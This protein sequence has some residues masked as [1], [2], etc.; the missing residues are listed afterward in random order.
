MQFSSAKSTMPFLYWMIAPGD[1][2][3]HVAQIGGA[4]IAAVHAAVLADQPFQMTVFFHF[5]ETHQRPAVGGQV[6]RVLVGTHVDA[7][8]LAHVVPFLARRLAGL[9]ADALGHVDQLGD[10]DRIALGRARR[11]R[12]GAAPDVERL[13][14]HDLD[15]LRL[16]A[17]EEPGASTH[18][19]LTGISLLGGLLMLGF[20]WRT[21]VFFYVDQER[22]VFRCLCVGIADE[23]R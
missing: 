16:L 3:A 22:L 10:L 21:S 9:A 14:R 18:V 7:N 11:G 20:H 1:G 15:F 8:F 6:M 19:D 12:R 4:A 5:C 23:R 2:Q 17:A 13:Q